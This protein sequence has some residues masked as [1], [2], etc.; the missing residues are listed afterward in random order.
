[1]IQLL[2]YYC[3]ALTRNE[4]DESDNDYYDTNCWL[5]VCSRTTTAFSGK[6]TVLLPWYSANS[7]MART[8]L[9]SS[10]TF[11]VPEYRFERHIIPCAGAN[12]H[13][14]MTPFGKPDEVCYFAYVHA[15]NGAI[16]LQCLVRRGSIRS[17]S[18][19]T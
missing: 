3:A 12:N 15:D 16:I 10:Y 7:I 17:I 19:H 4:A 1:V 5:P 9:L 2:C 11:N 18:A 14:S 13:S 8:E 6:N